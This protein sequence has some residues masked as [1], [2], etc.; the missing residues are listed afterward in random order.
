MKKFSKRSILLATSSAMIGGLGVGVVA[1]GTMA[2]ADSRPAQIAVVADSGVPGDS[3]VA[4][5]PGSTDAAPPAAPDEQPGR[6][7]HL[8]DALSPLVTD[9]TI[10]QAQA[11]KVID[12]IESAAPQRGRGGGKRLET[13]ATAIGISVAD[14]RSELGPTKSLADV[15]AAHGVD[16]Q[17]VIDALVADA[18]THIDQAVTDGKLTAEQAA[19]VKST[20]V[21]RITKRVNTPGM[22]GRG[23]GGRGGHRRH[24]GMGGDGD[25]PAGSA[26]PSGAATAAPSA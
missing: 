10:T 18:T 17:K 7:Q 24:D 2:N 19:T 5:D 12:A 13:A 11:D 21:D 8:T 22:P 9:G 26:A 1:V 6:R 4:G 15:A 25:S 16:V 3:G 20:L 23:A 14:L